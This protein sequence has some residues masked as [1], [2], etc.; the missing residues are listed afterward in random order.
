M[1]NKPIKIR[2]S[3]TKL[4]KQH[5]YEGKNGKYLNLVAW[6]NKTPSQYGDTHSVKQ[7]ISREAREAGEQEPYV[8]NLTLPDDA[9]PP[10]PRKVVTTTRQAA[11]AMDDDSDSIPF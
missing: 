10:T 4:L 3:V 11:A 9:P 2:V 1:S 7:E 8:G 5:I 6:P